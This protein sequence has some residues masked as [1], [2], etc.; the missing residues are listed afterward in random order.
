MENNKL[1]YES[2]SDDYT[3]EE[4]VVKVAKTRKAS[5]KNVNSLVKQK[6]E[7]NEP[8]NVSND[9]RKIIKVS[10]STLLLIKGKR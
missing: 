10:N 9:I 7:K 6:R 3:S 1:N 5:S 8:K 2:T 4:N